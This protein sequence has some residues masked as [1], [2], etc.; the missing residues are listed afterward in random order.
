VHLNWPEYDS[1]IESKKKT[2]FSGT[3]VLIDKQGYALAFSKHVIPA[4]RK[5]EYIRKENAK[6]PVYRHIGLYAYTYEALQH[7]S[8]LEESVYERNEVEGLE[9]MRFLY[10]GLKVKMVEVSYR[11]RETTGGVDS[12]PDI[13]RTEAILKKYGEFD[14]IR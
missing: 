4:V 8:S 2:P 1:L 9:Q 5:P 12:L 6:S 7:Y 13:E 3:T 10:N 14:F 11:G